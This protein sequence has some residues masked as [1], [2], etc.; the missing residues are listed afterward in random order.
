MASGIDRIA[1]ALERMAVALETDAAADRF[2]TDLL[3]SGS[4]SEPGPEPV[5]ADLADWYVGPDK[6]PWV[7]RG[8][9]AR[10]LTGPERRALRWSGGR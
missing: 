7:G 9:D 10:P 8:S 4:E 6:A 2:M 3:G 5:A 1:D